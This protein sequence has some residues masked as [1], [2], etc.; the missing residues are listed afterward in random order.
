MTIK[1]R[2]FMGP[3]ADEEWRTGLAITYPHVDEDVAEELARVPVQ[4]SGEHSV[5]AERAAL[6]R[7]AERRTAEAVIYA[8]GNRMSWQWIGDQL[9]VTA[10][11]AQQKYGKLP[12]QPDEYRWDSANQKAASLHTEDGCHARLRRDRQG[13]GCKCGAV[14]KLD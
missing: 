11:A 2:K 12:S 3:L 5:L 9:G 10:Q 7:A 1:R 4:P 6:V 8:R 13:W 14:G